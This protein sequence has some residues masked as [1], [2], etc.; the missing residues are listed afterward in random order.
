MIKILL[1]DDH[2]MVRMGLSAYLSLQA[3]MEVIDEASNGEEGHQKALTL[4]P[5]I[6]LMDLVMDVMDGIESTKIILSKWPEAKIIILTSFLDD[7]KVFP[8]MEA[9]ASSYLLKTST[10]S[11]IAEAIRSTYKGQVVLESEVEEK[12]QSDLKDSY[13][14]LYEDL[15]AR[16]KEVLTLIAEGCSNQEIADRLFITLKTVK[17]HVSNILMKLDVDDRTQATIYAFK[18]GFIK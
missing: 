9:G 2:E 14:A 8:A 6:I 4:K 10:A 7:E 11:E 17:T 13:Y 5:D 12:L 16:E 18:H 15:T 3:D 1:I